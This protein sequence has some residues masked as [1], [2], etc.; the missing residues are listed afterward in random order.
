MK[1]PGCRT[2][3]VPV[4]HPIA[5]SSGARCTKPDFGEPGLAE[6]GCGRGSPNGEADRARRASYSTTVSLPDTDTG[7]A[8][9]G[10]TFVS[11]LNVV[12]SPGILQKRVAGAPNH[13]A[14]SSSKPISTP[15][16]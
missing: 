8:T 7:A 6:R 16:R 13:L 12:P 9:K 15:A 3:A 2:K 4:D 14:V 10:Q 1:S 11:I 5:C